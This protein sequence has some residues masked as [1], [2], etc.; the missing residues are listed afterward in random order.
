MQSWLRVALTS[1]LVAL[2]V[3]CVTADEQEGLS[4]VDE[5]AVEDLDLSPEDEAA[6]D[7]FGQ[8]CGS[9]VCTGK[10]HCCNASCS[11]CVPFGMECTQEA[12]L[13]DDAEGELVDSSSDQ[14]QLAVD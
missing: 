8:Q 13:L 11:K 5:Q 6:L 4:Q 14:S 1:L 3:S 9:V 2:A 10:T 7:T 12:C